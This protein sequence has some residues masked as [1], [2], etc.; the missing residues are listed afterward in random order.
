[1]TA[2][3]APAGRAGFL[4]EAAPG[5][6]V[7]RLYAEDLEGQGYVAHLTRVWAHSPEALAV[8]SHLLRLSTESAGLD[9]RRRA[10]LVAAS[11]AALGDSYC[12]LAWG[13]R[14]AAIAGDEAATSALTGTDTALSD[15]ERVLAG[16]ARRV[17][18]DP[19]GT[20][21]QDVE[22][23]RR[24][25]YDDEQVFAITLFIALRLAFSTVNDALGAP[26]DAELVGRAP[27]AVRTAVTFGRPP[28]EGV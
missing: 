8:L 5:E 19:N 9:L 7:E 3:T 10:V 20:T 2:V 28:A 16:W 18:G 14:L 12:S 4:T 6:E 13:S 27:A 21:A 23:L 17:V 15:A 26:P 25:G 11:A 22:E 24:V 1:M